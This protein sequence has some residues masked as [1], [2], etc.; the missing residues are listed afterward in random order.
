MKKTNN[1][2]N[3]RGWYANLSKERKEQ[4]RKKR[5]ETYAQKKES[6][7]RTLFTKKRKNEVSCREYYCYKLQIRPIGKSILLQAGRLLQQYVV[8]M[9]VKIETSRLDYFRN[10]QK[11]IRAELY[12]RIIDS[13]EAGENRGSQ[14]GCRIIL[15]SS[16]IGGP[17]DMKKRYMDAMAL[18]QRFRKPDIFLTM[19]CDPN[20][21]EIKQELGP[22]DEV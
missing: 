4:I 9:Y 6:T 1:A 18:V 13:V 2:S 10:K 15:S 14:V 8:D 17:R 22:R 20:W 19:T 3:K 5:R 7:K 12:Q 11:E 21:S 16:F